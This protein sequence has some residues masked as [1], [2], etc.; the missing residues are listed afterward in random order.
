M[1][2]MKQ[3]ISIIRTEYAFALLVEKDAKKTANL[4]KAFDKRIKTHPYLGD[5]QSE[6]EL[7]ALADAKFNEITNSPAYTSQKWKKGDYL[8]FNEPLNLLLLLHQYGKIYS[9]VYTQKGKHNYVYLQ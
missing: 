9:L 6:Q 1:A 2:S 5:I 3:N 7:L 8:I 4:K